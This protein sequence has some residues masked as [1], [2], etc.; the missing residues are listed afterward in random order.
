MPHLHRTAL[1]VAA[2]C[3]ALPLAAFAMGGASGPK[4]TYETQGHLGEIIVNPYPAV[5]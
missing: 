2:V 1:A 5:P 4:T 3:T